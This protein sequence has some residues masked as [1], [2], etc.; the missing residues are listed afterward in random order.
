[1]T[2]DKQVQANRR[3]ALKSTGPQTPQGKAAVRLNANK[4]GL[5]SQEVLLPGEDEEALKALDEN[6]RVE[7]QPV[8][9]LE[10]LLVDRIIAAHWRLRRLGRVEAGIFV[11]EL[12]RG[13]A[14]QAN[15]ETDT[16]TLGMSF[17]RDANGANAFSK[18]SRYE[19]TIER[20]LYK[21]LHELQRLQA[22]RRHTEGNVPPPV[23]LDVDISGVPEEGL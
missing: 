1:M 21:A 8:G 17:I 22:A 15:S 6:L 4:H 14:S 9:E 23:A 7:L 2:S 5:R 13:L 16:A 3:N 12:S 10:G 11:R 19:T 20:S 18:L